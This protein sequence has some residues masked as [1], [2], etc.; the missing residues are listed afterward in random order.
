MCIRDRNVIV[1]GGGQTSEKLLIKTTQSGGG[2]QIAWSDGGSPGNGATLGS[3][4]F[5]GYSNGNSNASSDAK[6]QATASGS[7]SG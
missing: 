5:Q 4:G 2:L 6:I 1:G 7:H 3:I